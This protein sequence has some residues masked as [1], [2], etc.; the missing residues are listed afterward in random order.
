MAA[1]ATLILRLLSLTGLLVL[2]TVALTVSV[3]LAKMADGVPPLYVLMGLVIASVNA[4]VLVP[5][6]ALQVF[7]PSCVPFIVWL[8]ILWTTVLGGAWFA[9]AVKMSLLQDKDNSLSSYAD[10]PALA[11][12]YTA[13]QDAVFLA[14]A[15][16]WSWSLWLAIL[17]LRA[18]RRGA[19]GV[20]GCPT[21]CAKFLELKPPAAEGQLAEKHFRSSSTLP[22]P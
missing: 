12:R 22:S 6:F 2:A 18:W 4:L 21:R 8:E 19:S 3:Q 14:W 15:I 10:N 9:L 7:R 1:N 13:L 17:A 16:L 20:W 5:V 11:A